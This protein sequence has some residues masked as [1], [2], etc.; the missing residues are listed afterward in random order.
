[1][2]LMESQASPVP[3]RGASGVTKQVIIASTKQNDVLSREAD[4]EKNPV[5]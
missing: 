5:D 2:A 4:A 1:M 3:R